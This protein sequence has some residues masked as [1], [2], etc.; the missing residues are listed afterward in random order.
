MAGRLLGAAEAGL[1]HLSFSPP[2]LP[3]QGQSRPPQQRHP[4]LL[5]GRHVCQ[6]FGSTCPGGEGLRFINALV[7]KQKHK[8]LYTHTVT[9]SF[10]PRG[11]ALGE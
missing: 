4:L 9:L 2:N 5:S 1:P 6:L 10:I 8:Y 3:D 7:I 11:K